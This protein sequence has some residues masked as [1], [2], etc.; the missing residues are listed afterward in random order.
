VERGGEEAWAR[1]WAAGTPAATI[2]AGGSVR[3]RFRERKGRG[4]LGVVTI[5]C[6]AHWREGEAAR[7]GEGARGNGRPARPGRWGGAWSLKMALT[8]GP[9]L[10]AACESERGV[11][12]WLVLGGPAAGFWA[13]R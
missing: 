8:G 3:S 11:A 10:S 2:K 6:S 4:W 5:G 13:V 7:G 12:G 9:H 1:R